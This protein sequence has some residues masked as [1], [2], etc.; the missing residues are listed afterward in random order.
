MK[1]AL[2]LLGAL[3][4]GCLSQRPLEM[5]AL[6]SAKVSSDFASYE[7]RRVGLMPFVG[8]E[9]AAGQG[10][11]LQL[12]LYSELQQ[13][14]PFEVVML[15]QRDLEEVE[16]SEPFRHGWYRPR[17]IIELSKRHRRDSILF[18]QVTQQRF[19]PPQVLTL[20]VEMVAAE[21][22]LVIWSA[23]VHLDAGDQRVV[24]GLQVYYG[25][26]GARREGQSAEEW[27]LALLSPERFARFAAYQIA[28][29]L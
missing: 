16:V 29:L 2:S 22:G 19:F 24:D 7:V 10:H 5:P 12:G 27:R 21:T 1:P 3:L 6:A 20:Q 14:T 4:A 15:D 28:R 17:T 13:A 25:N 8:A 26:G 23:S 11:A 18:G 9:L